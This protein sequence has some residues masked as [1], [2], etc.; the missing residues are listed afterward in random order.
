MAEEP[1]PMTAT[2]LRTPRG[3]VHVASALQPRFRRADA[4][5]F[6]ADLTAVRQQGE[7]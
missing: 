5:L 6:Y 2:R 7:A 4:G 1:V 3:Y